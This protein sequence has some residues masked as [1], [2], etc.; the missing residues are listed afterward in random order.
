MASLCWAGSERRDAIDR[1]NSAAKVLDEI[2]AAP[3]QRIP[4]E[5][6]K[7]AKCI[8]VIPRL[9]KGGFVFGAEHGK[10]VATCRTA[11]V[12]RTIH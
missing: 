12:P 4:G 1:L 5:I 9:I 8:A 11:E 2:M 3:A 7:K 6:I 10:G